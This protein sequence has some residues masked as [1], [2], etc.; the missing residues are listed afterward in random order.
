MATKRRSKRHVSCFGYF[1]FC[2]T[3]RI[4]IVF[5][6]SKYQLVKVSLGGSLTQA[7]RG[8][9]GCVHNVLASPPAPSAKSS[10]EFN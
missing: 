2:L 5:L 9:H 10:N 4:V 8:A 7:V 3:T 1:V 6:C